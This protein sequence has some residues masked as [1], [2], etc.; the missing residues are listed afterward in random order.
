[1]WVLKDDTPDP[2]GDGR[3]LAY[4]LTYG[5]HGPSDATDVVITDLLPPEVTFRD[6]VPSQ[7][8]GPNPLIWS[9]GAL[10]AGQTGTIVVNVSVPADITG[11]ITNTVSISTNTQESNYRN[12]QDIEPTK[13][14]GSTAVEL[15]YFRATGTGDMVLLEWETAWEE[16][17]WGFRLYRGLTSEFEEAK[18]IHDEIGQGDSF[19]GRYYH[20]VD[21]DVVPGETY[22]YWLEDVDTNNN[23]VQHEPVRVSALYRIYAPMI[24]K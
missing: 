17:N 19:E 5:N 18:W 11:T 13:V 8:S 20:Y 12:N 21:R 2:V 10:P 14:E 24:T 23:A 3:D 1:V 7:T 6:A 4:S 22:Y 9:L 16:D 15:V